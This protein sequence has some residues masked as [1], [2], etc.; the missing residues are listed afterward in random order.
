MRRASRTDAN[1]AEIVKTLRAYGCSVLDLSA[2]GKGCPDLLIG[3]QGRNVLV[4]LKLP[5]RASRLNAVQRRW[6]MAW[7]GQVA[8]VR[9]V[10]AALDALG[11]KEWK[12]I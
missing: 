8:V 6:H 1:Q 11:I 10:G 9:C 4:E 3:Y 12:G 5:T 2:V 7:N